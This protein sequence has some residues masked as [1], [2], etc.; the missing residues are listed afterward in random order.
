[1]DSREKAKIIVEAL[2]DKKGIDIRVLDIRNVSVISDYFIIA[3]GSNKNQV[4]AMTDNVE[5]ELEKEKI[6]SNHVEGY[7]S[8]S[9]ILLDYDDIIIHLFNED[10]RAFYDLEKIWSDG[11]VVDM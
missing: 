4:Q 10:D 5:D 11:Q 7:G 1:M 9:W 3:S 2:R 8:G 6:Y